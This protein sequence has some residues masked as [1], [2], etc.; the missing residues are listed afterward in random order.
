MIRTAPLA[1]LALLTLSTVTRADVSLPAIFGDHMVLQ[2]DAKVPIWGN[3]AAGERVTVKVAGQEQA[4]TASE[5]GKWR[6]TLDPI[7]APEPVE[8]TVTGNNTITF[9]D[10]LFGE[11]WVCSGQS[12]MGFALKN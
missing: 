7:N 3:A 2:R 1:V 8:V 4:V 5:N 6:V 12:N 9:K 11:V 10:V